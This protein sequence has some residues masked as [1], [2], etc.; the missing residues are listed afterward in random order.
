MTEL[1][2]ILG[3]HRRLAEHNGGRRCPGD[4]A[5]WLK[6]VAGFEHDGSD[7]LYPE[8]RGAGLVACGH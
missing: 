5:L 4:Q 3:Y 1:R 2:C 8:M 7:T 6:K